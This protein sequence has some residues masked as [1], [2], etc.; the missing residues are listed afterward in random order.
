MVLGGV[1]G[2]FLSGEE[3]KDGQE[4]NHYWCVGAEAVAEVVG[5]DKGFEANC[6]FVNNYA[7]GLGHAIWE[8]YRRVVL[9]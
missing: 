2:C 1:G 7:D 4:L 9:L 5:A 6:G 8:S 3:A